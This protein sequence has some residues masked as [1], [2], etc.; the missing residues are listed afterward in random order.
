MSNLTRA[1]VYLTGL[2]LGLSFGLGLPLFAE[3]TFTGPAL[4]R[5][6]SV[7]A[8]GALAVTAIVAGVKVRSADTDLAKHQQ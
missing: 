5:I 8:L 6:A 3:G 7:V 4:Y 1:Q 2:L